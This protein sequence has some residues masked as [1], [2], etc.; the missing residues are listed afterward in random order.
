[1]FGFPWTPH[2][3]DSRARPSHAG[4]RGKSSLRETRLPRVMVAGRQPWRGP[5][6][7]LLCVAVAASC[8]SPRAG[9]S[10][11]P[12]FSSSSSPAT[13]RPA[14]EVRLLARSGPPAVGK[15][16]GVTGEEVVFLPAP[17]WNVESRT[18]RIQDISVIEVMYA[19]RSPARTGL[20]SF[21]ASFVFLGL[22]GGADAEYNDDYEVA[23]AAAFAG[24][25]G[26]GLIGTVWQAISNS[27]HR[28]TYHFDRMSEGEKLI[29]LQS[30]MAR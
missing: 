2:P 22:V 8:A 3:L 13:N 20:I 6:A 16:I 9:S 11:G 26:V 12:S 24:G 23:L 25:I 30:I 10:G 15:V 5:V 19:G 1:M 7:A 18:I 28:K 17:Y 29:A 4:G 27:L 14:D 21:A